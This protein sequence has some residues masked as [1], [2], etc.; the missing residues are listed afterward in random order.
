MVEDSLRQQ[1]VRVTDNSDGDEF[2]IVRLEHVE[3]AL[4]VIN[5]YGMQE[6]KEGEE[7]KKR[8]LESWVRLKKELLLIEGRGEAVV[9]MGDYNRSV[10]CDLEIKLRSAMEER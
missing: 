1:A 8:V 2:L 4:N 6:G 9:V 10:G 7:G 3:P 5:L